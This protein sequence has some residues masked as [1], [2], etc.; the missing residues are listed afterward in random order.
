M[1]DP[2]RRQARD[3]DP[4]VL[5]LFDR[6]FHGDIDRRGFLAGAARH[7]VGASGVAQIVDLT[8]QLRGEAG[9]RQVEGARVALAQ[10]GGGVIDWKTSV[11]TSHILSA[12]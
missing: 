11:S 8:Q 7:A 6:Y 9:P 2:I 12:T 1:S 3:F 4:E 5:R 10:I